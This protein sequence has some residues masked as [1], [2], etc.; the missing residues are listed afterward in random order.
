MTRRTCEP[1]TRG[2]SPL[3]DMS[4]TTHTARPLDRASLIAE[5]KTEKAKP[6]SERSE[7]KL[8]RILEGLRHVDGDDFKTTE[9]NRDARITG[10]Y[11]RRW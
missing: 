6:P 1:P 7:D 10:L 9:P 11:P 5:L 2:R 4:E 3:R 8:R